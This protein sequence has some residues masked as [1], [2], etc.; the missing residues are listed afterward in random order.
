MR[1]PVQFV[2]LIRLFS[3]L[4][5]HFVGMNQ[6]LKCWG[7]QGTTWKNEWFFLRHEPGSKYFDKW[8]GAFFCLSQ[9]SLAVSQRGRRLISFISTAQTSELQTA[10][11]ADPTN[12]WSILLFFKQSHYWRLNPIIDAQSHFLYNIYTIPLTLFSYRLGD[13]QFVTTGA[14]CWW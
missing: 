3:F 9:P 5:P 4:G 13:R 10:T 11:L 12:W 1:A 8:R 7:A 6:F 14:I 2:N